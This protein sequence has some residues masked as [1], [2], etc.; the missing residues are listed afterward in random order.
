MDRVAV[1]NF[2]GTF[3]L[4]FRKSFVMDNRNVI[5]VKNTTSENLRKILGN[6]CSLE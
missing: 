4:Y 2:L 3:P 6:I 1:L 5:N